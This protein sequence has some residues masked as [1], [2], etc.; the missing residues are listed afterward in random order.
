MSD[1]ASE[2]MAELFDDSLPSVTELKQKEK[3]RQTDVI[4]MESYKTW[5]IDLIG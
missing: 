2:F 3:D 4:W 5:N 1:C